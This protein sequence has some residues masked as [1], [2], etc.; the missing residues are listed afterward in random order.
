[1]MYGGRNLS[2]LVL[3]DGTRLRLANY[4]DALPAIMVNG[5]M[6]S[7]RDLDLGSI[8]ITDNKASA[9]DDTDGE[10]Y[11]IIHANS[12]I[13]IKFD[14]DAGQPA[15]V[16]LFFDINHWNNVSAGR[17]RKGLCGTLHICVDLVVVDDG[18][19]KGDRSADDVAGRNV[20]DGKKN[21]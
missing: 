10:Y 21:G 9:L 19:F 6:L 4:N 14:A 7:Y 11:E 8:R 17:R 2:G 16:H 15:K 18:S 20:V 5:K 3:F 13:E 12:D 1:M